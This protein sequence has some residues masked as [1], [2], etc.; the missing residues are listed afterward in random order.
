M[1]RHY[2]KIL[3]CFYMCA[4]LKINLNLNKS[5]LIGLGVEPAEVRRVAA[6][7]N[8]KAGEL[9]FV[10]LGVLV[11]AKMHRI[12]RWKAVF[13]TFETR[14]AMW[15][16]SCLSIGGR[17]T[18]IKSVLECIPN[19]YLSFFKAPSGVVKGLEKIIRNFLWGGSSEVNKIPWVSWNRVSVP[20]DMGGIGIS[21]LSDVNVSL[22]SKWYWRYKNDAIGLWRKV[23]DS[24][25]L[26]RNCW[27]SVP[28]NNNIRGIWK[29]I[30]SVVEKTAVGDMKLAQKFGCK[31]GSGDSIRFWLDSWACD[32]PLKDLFPALFRLESDKFC[33]VRD[34]F[35]GESSSYSGR[36]NWSKPLDRLLS[37]KA[38]SGSRDRWVW[39]GGKNGEFSVREVKHFLKSGYD[40]SNY[41]RFI[42]S[43]WVPKKCNILLWRAEMGR[44]ATTDALIKRNCFSRNN[45]CSLCEDGE[46]SA[47]H[48]FC[49]CVV[50]ANIWYLI[51]RWCRI[52]PIFAFYIR[53]LTSVHE[54]SGL[55]RVAKEA[56]HGIILTGCWCIWKAR[57]ER[58]FNNNRKAILD[59]FQDIK[60]L[61]FI[62]YRN[63]S[64]NR[65]KKRR[66]NKIGDR[67][68]STAV[69]VSGN[70]GGWW[71]RQ[72]MTP[73]V[74]CTSS[75]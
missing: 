30:V 17:L 61:S 1:C 38:P 31:L 46:E 23:I 26:G 53:D 10:H 20:V 63:R 5:E 25:H 27:K 56:L 70:G 68:R 37:G 13:D 35:D 45:V 36:W 66:R 7:F 4:G 39:D 18:L 32:S 22:L 11:G 48:L 43:K 50:A 42:W 41:F 9:P 52:S 51:S 8:C 69:V 21:S 40:F 24:F 71:R 73:A 3:R 67:W 57:N 60:G 15:K 14:L 33:C 2:M 59:I 54:H 49:S 19:Y 44:I 64:K 16:A 72:V 47:E 34:R 58:R 74:M 75:V 28:A 6:G 65:G 12:N 55:H 29:N 62:W